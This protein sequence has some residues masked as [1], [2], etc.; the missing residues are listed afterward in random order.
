[1][2]CPCC[3]PCANCCECSG[4]INLGASPGITDL[5]TTLAYTNPCNGDTYYDSDTNPIGLYGPKYYELRST[6][7]SGGQITLKQEAY[8]RYKNIDCG[9]QFFT[10]GQLQYRGK[11]LANSCLCYSESQ[12]FVETL[13]VYKHTCD[14]GWVKIT[15]EIYQNNRRVAYTRKRTPFACNPAPADFPDVPAPIAVAS[16]YPCLPMP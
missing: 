12:V 4:I 16:S 15:D 9:C 7:Y 13:D 5:F 8:D 14:A 3:N 6:F 10:L 11:I 1:M 2:A